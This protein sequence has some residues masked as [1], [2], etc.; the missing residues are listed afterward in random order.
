MSQTITLDPSAES[1]QEIQAAVEDN[2]KRI[3]QIIEKMAKEQEEIS[4]L[5][6]ETQTILDRLKAA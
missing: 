1:P 3:D 6:A 4:L 5:R 2:L